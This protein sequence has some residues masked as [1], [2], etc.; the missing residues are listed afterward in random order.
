MVRLPP[1][2][3]FQYF[4]KSFR[5]FF[6]NDGSFVPGATTSG[7]QLEFGKGY[8]TVNVVLFDASDCPV[9]TPFG[10]EMIGVINRGIGSG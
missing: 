4:L 10:A 7:I 6:I 2:V 1:I 5:D 9:S 8:S 3:W